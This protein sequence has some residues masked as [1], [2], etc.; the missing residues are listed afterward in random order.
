[1][2]MFYEWVVENSEDYH[3]LRAWQAHGVN[4][5]MKCIACKIIDD[6]TYEK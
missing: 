3:E 2:P 6:L 4:N 1:M 5:P